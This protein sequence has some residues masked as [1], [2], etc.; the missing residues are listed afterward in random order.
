MLKGLTGNR[1]LQEMKVK[2]MHVS[3]G[4]HDSPKANAFVKSVKP[5]L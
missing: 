1:S 2:M 3:S 4:L 5:A